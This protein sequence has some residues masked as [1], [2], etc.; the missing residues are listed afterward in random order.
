[1]SWAFKRDYE[2]SWLRPGRSLTPED[3]WNGNNPKFQDPKYEGPLIMDSV[4]CSVNHFNQDDTYKIP[5]LVRPD[6]M[7]K[8]AKK[9]HNALCK[10]ID[11]KGMDPPAWNIGYNMGRCL[12]RFQNSGSSSSGTSKRGAKWGEWEVESVWFFPRFPFTSSC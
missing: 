6:G 4:L 2:T 7:P 8:S 10:R 11:G 12:I 1:M 5:G 3:W 9:E